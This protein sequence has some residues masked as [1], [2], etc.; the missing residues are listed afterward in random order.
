M[1][2]PNPT[3]YYKNNNSTEYLITIP[4]SEFWVKGISEN[5][6]YTQVKLLVKFNMV[7]GVC[8]LQY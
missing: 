2:R 3:S 1:D 8:M 7:Y 6:S 4:Y 5:K